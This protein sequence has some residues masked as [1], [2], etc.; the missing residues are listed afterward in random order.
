VGDAV[1]ARCTALVWSSTLTR[2]LVCVFDQQGYPTIKYFTDSTDP[3]GDKYEGGRDYDALK[4]WCDEN[5]GP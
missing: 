3:M 4:E 5:L 2:Y 1:C